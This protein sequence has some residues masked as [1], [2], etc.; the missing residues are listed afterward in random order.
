MLTPYGVQHDAAK[1]SLSTAA[2]ERSSARRQHRLPGGL[3]LVRRRDANANGPRRECSR[4]G[5]GRLAK[6]VADRHRHDHHAGRVA[7]TG[8]LA[9]PLTGRWR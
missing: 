6:P 5:P 1:I 3:R 8:R 2:L 9:E 4:G 7:I